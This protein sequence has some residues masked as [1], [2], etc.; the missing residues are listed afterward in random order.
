MAKRA[1]MRVAMKTL[2]ELFE[3]VVPGFDDDGELP[4]ATYPVDHAAV[5]AAVKVATTVVGVQTMALLSVTSTESVPGVVPP[6]EM[7]PSATVTAS[8]LLL[9]IEETE[10][11]AMRA[12]S[13]LAIPLVSAP[14]TWMKPWHKMALLGASQAATVQSTHAVKAV[15][16]ASTVAVAGTKVMVAK[17]DGGANV[18]VVS[19]F[20]FRKATVW[21]NQRALHMKYQTFPQAL[22]QAVQPAGVILIVASV[23]HTAGTLAVA[24]ALHPSQAIFPMAFM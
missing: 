21:A 4:G 8:I 14:K 23:F 18:A 22:D 9:A 17:V 12:G 19:F 6:T 2:A 5:S 11:A 1:L 24:T 7:V 10:V 3:L 16:I 20:L 13:E 15:L